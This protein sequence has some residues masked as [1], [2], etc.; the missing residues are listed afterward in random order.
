MSDLV[1]L[2]VAA[3]TLLVATGVGLLVRGRSAEP[4]PRLGLAVTTLVGMCALAAVLPNLFLLGL[5]R[6]AVLGLAWS[7]AGLGIALHARRELRQLRGRDFGIAIALTLL[8]AAPWLHAATSPPLYHDA[9]L[10]WWPKVLEAWNGELPDPTRLTLT[11]T[12]QPYPRG[13]AWLTV[14][15]CVFGPPTPQAMAS[16]AMAWAWLTALAMVSFARSVGRTGLGLAAAALFV[17][18][19]DV[20]RHAGAGMADCAIGGAALLAAIGLAR[21][22]S[23]PEGHRIAI[24]AAIGAASLKEEGTVVL[25]A[26][27]AHFAFDVLWRADRRWNALRCGPAIA[28]LVPFTLLRAHVQQTRMEALPVLLHDPHMLLLRGIAVCEQVADFALRHSPVAGPLLLGALL[29]LLPR[30]WPRPLT[31]WPALLLLPVAM[32][33][34]ATTT[35]AVQWHVQTTFDRLLI[36]LLP[37]VLLAAALRLAGDANHTTAQVAAPATPR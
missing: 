25:L 23:A 20:A 14:L 34:Y 28:V 36:E 17:L 18:A 19:P 7:A 12:N 6:N 22:T 30:G 24:A 10:M 29:V 11:H 26:V 8:T 4:A 37:T 31:P 3:T 1:P 21:R 15:G 9:M 2:A 5:P 32:L 27:G 13:M 33:V 35:V 16:L